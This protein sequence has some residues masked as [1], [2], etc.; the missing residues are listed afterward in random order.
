[1]IVNEKFMEV[2]RVR[3]RQECKGDLYMKVQQL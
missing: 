2:K 3:R 1:M